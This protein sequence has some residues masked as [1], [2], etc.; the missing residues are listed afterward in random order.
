MRC[1]SMRRWRFERLAQHLYSID[2]YLDKVL[3]GRVVGHSIESLI[4]LRLS[5][6]S[7]LFQFLICK[8]ARLWQCPTAVG[9]LSI[10]VLSPF[11]HAALGVR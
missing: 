2:L 3:F 7:S 1:A 10:F 11:V 8:N 5:C 6:T 4:A 9:P